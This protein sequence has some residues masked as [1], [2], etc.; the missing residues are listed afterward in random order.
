[1][2]VYKPHMENYLVRSTSSIA[3]CIGAFT[4]H[5]SVAQQLWAAGVP[6]WFLQPEMVFDVENIL[7]VVPLLEPNLGLSDPDAHSAG[8]PP[9]LYTGNST[10]EKIEVIHRVT[11][12]TPWYHDPFDTGFA[13]APSLPPIA[14]ISSHAAALS[15]SNFGTLLSFTTGA[16]H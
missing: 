9:V 14:S 13:R 15:L 10:T 11:Q 5:P 16:Y 4:S 8:A 1:M 6:F 3:E 7:A 2:T 12:Y